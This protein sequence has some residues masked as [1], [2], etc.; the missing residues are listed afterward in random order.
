MC[1]FQLRQNVLTFELFLFVMQQPSKKCE[2]VNVFS[3]QSIML[4]AWL[5]D[6][7]LTFSLSD[8]CESCTIFLTILRLSIVSE[9]YFRNN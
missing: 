3:Y 6:E 8:G 7:F 1:F 2:I 5:L 4:T 9:A